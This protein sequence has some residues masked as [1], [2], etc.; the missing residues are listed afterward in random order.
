MVIRGHTVACKL[1][2]SPQFPPKIRFLKIIRFQAFELYFDHGNTKASDLGRKHVFH[3][4][5]FRWLIALLEWGKMV[6]DRPHFRGRASGVVVGVASYE[7]IR[8]YTSVL[9]KRL[10][11]V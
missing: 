11:Q 6:W 4:Q 9:C 10:W 7:P 5:H 1:G 3:Y 8:A 2:F